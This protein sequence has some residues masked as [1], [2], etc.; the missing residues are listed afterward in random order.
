MPNV[1]PNTE[2]NNKRRRQQRGNITPADWDTAD[3][4]LLRHAIAIVG[5]RGGALRLGYTRDGGSYAIGI[6]GDGDPY[7]EYVRPSDDLSTYL[8]GLISDWEEAD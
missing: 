3:A 1:K 8:E 7:T 6:L 2:S 5:R 4:E